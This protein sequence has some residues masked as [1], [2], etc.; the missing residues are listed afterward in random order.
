VKLSETQ[1]EAIT[2]A[3]AES[4]HFYR[5]PG[6]YWHTDRDATDADFATGEKP[7]GRGRSHF[8]IH[9]VRALEERGLVRRVGQDVEWRAPREVT[10]AG[11]AAVAGGQP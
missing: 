5:W 7:G 4:G 6:G 11:R 9:T 2:H 10:E 8:T 3:I 1:R